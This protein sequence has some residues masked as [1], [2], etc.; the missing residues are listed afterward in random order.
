[1]TGRLRA[2]AV[3]AAAILAVAFMWRPAAAQSEAEGALLATDK[4]FSEMS[5]KEGQAKAFLAYAADDIRA[6]GTGGEPVIGKAAL[7]AHYAELA[8]KGE[9]QGSL[10]W[11]PVE[12]FISADGTMG[13][14]NGHWVFESVREEGGTREVV[15]ATGHYISVWTKN[16]AGAWKLAADIGTADPPEAPATPTPP[17]AP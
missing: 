3:I 6:F 2:L 8:T 9:P 7:E 16:A 14:T 17:V 11:E 4:A 15:R 1:M 5:A 10:T 12:A 13:W